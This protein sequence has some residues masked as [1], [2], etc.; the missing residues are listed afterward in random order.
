MRKA[1]IKKM[2]LPTLSA[3]NQAKEALKPKDSE[4]P[5]TLKAAA[6]RMVTPILISTDRVYS[7]VFDQNAEV[8]AFRAFKF[9]IKMATSEQVRMTSSKMPAIKR[10]SATITIVSSFAERS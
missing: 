4:R 6:S 5:T 8:S 3:G 10:V 2:R 1:S 7:Q 9:P